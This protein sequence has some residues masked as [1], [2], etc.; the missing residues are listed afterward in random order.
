MAD[1]RECKKAEEI[2]ALLEEKCPECEDGEI[3]EDDGST[4]ECWKCYGLGLLPTELGRRVM[5]FLARRRYAA[6]RKAE[7]DKEIS[8]Q[9][10]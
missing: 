10:W 6:K 5:D 3:E 2:M 9:S 4:S 7:D 8:R 1:E